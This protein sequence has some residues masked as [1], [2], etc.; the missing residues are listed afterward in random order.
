MSLC[1]FY[2]VLVCLNNP[3]DLFVS[4][5]EQYCRLNGKFSASHFN[6]PSNIGLFVPGS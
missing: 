3:F 4:G 6:T 5:K 2:Y 1:V